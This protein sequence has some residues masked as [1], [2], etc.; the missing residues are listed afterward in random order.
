MGRPIVSQPSPN[1]SPSIIDTGAGKG[2]SPVSYSFSHRLFRAA[3]WGTWLLLAAW[4]PPPLHGWRRMLLQLFG[5]R[6]GKGARVYG[7]ARVWYPP[8]LQM[9]DNAVIGWR[10]NCY[11]QGPITL[12]DHAVVSQFA[13]LVS[14]T[15]NIDRP[16]FQLETRPIH[17][18]SHAWVAAN[19]FVGPGVSVGEGA[20][21]GACGVAVRDLPAWTIHAGNPARYI[22]DRKPQS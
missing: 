5:A 20:V 8:N 16:G 12:G 2:L 11:C 15:H 6:M 13:H 3:W 19:A 18:G 1:P 10:V 14:S 17:I 4:T 9:G 7:S 21:L 22:R